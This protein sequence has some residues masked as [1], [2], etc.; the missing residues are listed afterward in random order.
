MKGEGDG[1]GV[2]V[3]ENGGGVGD[4]D[5]TEVVPDSGI[6]SA[7]TIGPG[8]AAGIPA[9]VQPTDKK[10]VIRLYV[11]GVDFPEREVEFQVKELLYHGKLEM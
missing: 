9:A 2:G 6:F 8:A 1:E 10:V 7:D 11:P 4:A 5:R 3:E